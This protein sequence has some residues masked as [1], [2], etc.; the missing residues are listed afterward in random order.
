[1]D[2]LSLDPITGRNDIYIGH[3]NHFISNC[4]IFSLQQSQNGR[5]EESLFYYNMIRCFI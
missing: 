1:M 2:A 4:Y 5:R 3:K